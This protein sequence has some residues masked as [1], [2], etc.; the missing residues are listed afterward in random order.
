MISGGIEPP[1]FCV[2]D[3]CDNHYTTRPTERQNEKRDFGKRPSDLWASFEWRLLEYQYPDLYTILDMGK[4][5]G[6]PSST[7]VFSTVS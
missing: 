1:T 3:R 7:F 5:H 4:F 6:E 2:L